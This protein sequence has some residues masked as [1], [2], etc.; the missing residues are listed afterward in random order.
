MKIR[1]SG[2]LPVVGTEIDFQAT[3][4]WLYR[5]RQMDLPYFQHNLLPYGKRIFYYME[6]CALLLEL[7]NSVPGL[8][9]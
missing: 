7:L 6:K 5:L 3:R 1:K 8:I 4:N 2:D 9:C